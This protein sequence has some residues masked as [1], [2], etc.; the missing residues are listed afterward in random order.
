LLERSGDDPKLKLRALDDK[1]LEPFWLD[2]Q[3]AG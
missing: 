2:I 1:T 3:E